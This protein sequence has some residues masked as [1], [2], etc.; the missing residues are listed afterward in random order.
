MRDIV[1]RYASVHDHADVEAIFQEVHQLHV[2]LRPDCYQPRETLLSL[3]EF[4]QAVEEKTLL[5]ADWNGQVVGVL[6]YSERSRKVTA[7]MTQ[8]IL[9]ID[10]LAVTESLRSRGIG[11]QLLAFARE[12]RAQQHFDC[13]ELQVNAQNLPARAFYEA[14]GFTERSINLELL[15]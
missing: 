11:R 14:T 1:I 3:E 15:E 8:R 5:V 10:C 6:Y 13:L 12:I 7:Q 2:T 4:Q 9:F